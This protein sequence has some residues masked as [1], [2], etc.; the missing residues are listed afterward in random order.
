MAERVIP[1]TLRRKSNRSILLLALA[2][3]VI[4]AVLVGV[5]LSSR[6]GSGGEESVAA[7]SVPVSVPVVV[8]ARDIP[9]RSTITEDMLAVKQLPPDT[10]QGVFA[11]TTPLVGAITL[12]P[13]V[14]GE[15]I[16]PIKVA[17][18]GREQGLAFVIPEGMRAIS[19]TATEVVGSGGLIVPGDF[20]DVIATFSADDVGSDKAVTV[21][22][23]VQ[24]LAVAQSVQKVVS[25]TATGNDNQ[26]ATAEGGNAGLRDGEVDPNPSAKSV[27]LS[28][29]PEGAQ[30]L[31]LAEQHGQLRLLLRPFGDD[32]Q[33]VVLES[34]L[35]LSYWQDLQASALAEV[36]PLQ[37]AA[38]TCEIDRCG[39]RAVSIA[40]AP[41]TW[42]GGLIRPGDRADVILAFQDGGAITILQ[43]IEVLSIDQDL[44]SVAGVGEER[45]VVSEGEENPG[46]TTATLSAWPDEAEMLVAAEEFANGTTRVTIVS[47]SIAQ[48]L[49]VPVGIEFDCVG[50]VRLVLRHV[51]QSGPVDL[52]PHGSCASLFAYIWGL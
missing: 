8:A 15:P 14:A 23:N 20:V 51:G 40:V 37:Q 25:P 3:G 32:S 27:T 6:G 24:V 30:L 45:T 48:A 11:N 41:G 18:P 17:E 39:Q 29:T 46:A 33:Q 44:A 31:F 10:L 50:S 52:E 19:I 22:Q 38:A 5:I 13:I 36:V 12:Q 4:S 7:G 9:A 42:S 26:V 49:G 43:D 47:P 35:D 2:F 1:A 34:N 21:L 16:L 28:V